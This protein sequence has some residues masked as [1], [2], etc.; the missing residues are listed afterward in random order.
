MPPDPEWLVVDTARDYLPHREKVAQLFEA[1]FHRQFSPSGWQQYYFDNPYGDAIVALAYAGPALVAH[2]ALIPALACDGSSEVRYHLSLSTMVHPQHRSVPLFLQLF[3]RVHQRAARAGSGFVL[4]FPNANLHTPLRRCFGYVPIVET[5]LCNWSP[6]RSEDAGSRIEATPWTGR[7]GQF[8]PPAS[9]TY[10]DWRTKQNKARAVR[11]NGRL[12][13]VYKVLAGGILNVL[14]LDACSAA[15]CRDDL[16]HLA[17]AEQCSCVRITR[18]H[19]SMLAIAES[20]LAAH[21]GYWVRMLARPLCQPVPN[22]EFNLLF[23]DIF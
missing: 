23:C 21:D 3:E 22:L 16:A 11:V 7:R 4:G 14:G 2:Q 12:G 1:T 5:P 15:A 17:R 20:E 10:W 9:R 8:A 18:A 6:P 13:A 19:A